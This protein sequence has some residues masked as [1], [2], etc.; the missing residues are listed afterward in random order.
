MTRS[1][2]PEAARSYLRP[3]TAQGHFINFQRLLEQNYGRVPFASAQ[4]GKSFRNEISP[5]QG[6]LRVR[7]ASSRCVFCLH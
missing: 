1:A 6:L 7:C 2:G 5:R 4:I 3:E